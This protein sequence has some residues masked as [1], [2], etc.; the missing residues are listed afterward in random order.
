VDAKEVPAGS[1]L[2][3]DEVSTPDN[4]SEE[5]VKPE[6]ELPE[7]PVKYAMETEESNRPKKSFTV[8]LPIINKSKPNTS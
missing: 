4:D 7:S 2:N 1:S 6:S 3:N 5:E 8:L